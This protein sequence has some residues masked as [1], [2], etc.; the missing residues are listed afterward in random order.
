MPF[1][2][3]FTGRFPRQF[4][5]LFWGM[6][7]STS[8]VSMIWPFQTIYLQQ[9]LDI[10]LTPITLLLSLSAVAVLGSSIFFGMII[11]RM[12]RKWPMVVGL[13]AHAGSLILFSFAETYTQFALLMVLNGIVNPIYR[14]AADAMVADLIPP[15]DRPEAIALLRLSHNLGISIGPLVGGI[16]ASTS[17]FLVFSGGAV[18]L[19]LYA[20]LVFVLGRE[21]MPVR[22][23]GAA[24]RIEIFG[25]Y[26]RI[27]RDTP[28]LLFFGLFTLAQ[29]STVLMWQLMP[30][31]AKINFGVP[32][33]QY[34]AIPMTN[35]M[36][37]VSLQM[38]ITSRS[39]VRPALIMLASG[40]LIY[41]L[42]AGSVALA[43]DFWGFWMSMVFMTFGE[44]LLVP[45]GSTHVANAAPAD[46]RG[47]YM[48]VFGLSWGVA[49]GIAPVLGGAL[50]DQIGPWAIWI[51]GLVAG[52]LSASGFIVMYMRQKAVRQNSSSENPVIKSFPPM[53]G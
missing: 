1:N 48:G 41:G 22:P 53:E 39:K 10:P 43:R 51:T 42:S 2:A 35:A 32:E 24:P 28:F 31:Y 20:L 17:Y 33:S 38:M 50:N 8:G 14:I 40:A 49:Q 13:A 7:I 46:M 4:R 36:M 29:F 19:F 3:I 12:G 9:K 23:S 27:I 44:M 52:I 37:V 18:G 15:E 5:L 47:R 45:T 25:G 11:D 26:D 30:V 34:G 16:L 21:T 6:L